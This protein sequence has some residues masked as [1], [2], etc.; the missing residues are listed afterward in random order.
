MLGPSL[1]KGPPIPLT[2]QLEDNHEVHNIELTYPV[3]ESFEPVLG[4]LC[5][6]EGRLGHCNHNALSA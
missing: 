5:L 3:L 2:D 4:L 1:L 6:S